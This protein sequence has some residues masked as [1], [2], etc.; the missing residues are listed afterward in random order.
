MALRILS[1]HRHKPT[2][3][4]FKSS[5]DTVH[6]PRNLSIYGYTHP[7]NLTQSLNIQSFTVLTASIIFKIVLIR[8]GRRIL[9][10]LELSLP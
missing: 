5:S 8:T 10:N 1:T 4:K 6:T 9:Y 3:C 7:T 2:F